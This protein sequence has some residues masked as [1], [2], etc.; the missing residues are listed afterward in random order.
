VNLSVAALLISIGTANKLP[1]ST[2]YIT[3]M[4]AMGAAL[5]DR[6]WR[7]QDAEKRLAGILMVLGGWLITGFL[8]ASGAFV[9]AS[10]IVLGGSWGVFLA[11]GA[12]AFGLIRM[13]LVNGSDDDEGPPAGSG[14]PPMD[15]QTSRRWASS[16]PSTPTRAGARG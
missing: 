3:F 15:R 7:W 12:V 6:V 8:A 11:V 13:K 14:R 16:R 5:G 1:L 10:L 4:A 9:M 2:T